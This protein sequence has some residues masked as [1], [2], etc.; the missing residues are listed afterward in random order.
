V[1]FEHADLAVIAQAKGGAPL[2]E[3][4]TIEAGHAGLFF[5]DGRHVDTVIGAVPKATLD[6][7][8]KQHLG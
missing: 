6:Q 2:L 3:A 5:K 7:K 1:R 4:V 8:V